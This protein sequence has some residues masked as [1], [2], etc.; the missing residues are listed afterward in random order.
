MVAWQPWMQKDFYLPQ[1]ICSAGWHQFQP[2]R[3]MLTVHLHQLHFYGYHG[4]YAGEELA[5]NSFEVNLDVTYDPSRSQMNNLATLIS[6]EELFRIVQQRMNYPTPLLEELAQAIV[7][8]IKHEFAQV[9]EIKIS[10]FKLQ[11]PIEQLQGKVGIS[12]LR[13]F[14]P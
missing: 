5:G 6:Y 12:F 13:K 1:G 3:T 7:M 10:I 14:E 4:L 9:L 11:A 8:T 2:L